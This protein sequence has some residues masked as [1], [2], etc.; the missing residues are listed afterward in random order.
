MT[1]FKRSERDKWAS[2]FG[3]TTPQLHLGLPGL[4]QRS[5][6]LYGKVLPRGVLLP[7]FIA[8]RPPQNYWMPPHELLRYTY[9]PGQIVLGKFAGR[10]IGHLDDRPQIT[11]AGA[12]AG[13][14]STILEPNLC[15][16]PGLD[17]GARSEAR[18]GA[19]GRFAP[20]ARP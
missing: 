20:R 18:I 2:P 12:R 5:R 13:K 15:L 8:D 11:I 9:A 17:A 19:N 4:D 7:R 1:W 6:E 14:T 10:L 16:Y 3:L